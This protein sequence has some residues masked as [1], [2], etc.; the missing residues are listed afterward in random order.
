MS[1][2][3]HA[4]LKSSKTVEGNGLLSSAKHR[5]DGFAFVGVFE[6]QDHR[7]SGLACVTLRPHPR[8]RCS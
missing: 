1:N 3:S 6:R 4:N 2:E 7:W 5:L 8:L